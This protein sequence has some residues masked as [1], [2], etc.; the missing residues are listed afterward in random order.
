[1]KTLALVLL[2][3]CA[4]QLAATPASYPFVEVDESL[5][6]SRVSRSA[7]IALLAMRAEAEAECT[8]K[9][10]D[11]ESRA[12]VALV[13]L[14]SE[15]RR[16]NTNAWWAI[17]GPGLFGCGVVVSAILGALGGFLMGGLNK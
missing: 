12:K 17:Y 11:C 4:P 10:I 1:M 9:A 7:A 13:K 14:D 5:E 3:S 6:G 16:A 15:T 2:C 8:A